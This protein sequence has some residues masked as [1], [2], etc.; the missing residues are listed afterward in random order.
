MPSTRTLSFTTT[1]GMINRIHGDTANM[2]PFSYPS[3]ATG[4]AKFLALMLAIPYL[5]DTCTTKPVKF[6]HFPRR[7]SDQNVLS[8]LGHQLCRRS[9]TPNKLGSFPNF[10]LDIMD[11]GTQRYIC[12]RQ[13]VSWLNINVISCHNLISD[14]DAI[15]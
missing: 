12:H 2:G 6:S 11:D 15:R 3:G 1:H 14:G 13:A 8:F 5:T 4:L 9:C 10:H 7:Q